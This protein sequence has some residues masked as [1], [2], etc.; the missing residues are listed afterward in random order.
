M[1][2]FYAD[3]TVGGDGSTTTDDT[4]ATTGLANGG[5]RTRLVPMFTQ[6]LNIAKWVRDTAA[7]TIGYK[8][9]ANNSAGL[10]NSRANAAYDAQL[11]A[12]R[13]LASA[14]AQVSLAAMQVDLAAE[15]K[16]LASDQVTLAAA[17]VVLA[18][19]WATKLVDPVT[20]GLYSARYYSQ[21]ALT[22]AQQAAAVTGIPIIDPVADRDKVMT[23]KA[24]GSGY[25]LR[26]ANAEQLAYIDLTV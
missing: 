23:A 22:Y 10:A 8:N 19:D 3:P 12:E 17:E 1:S 26:R 16:D 14:Q 5:F 9:E 7:L 13:A 18:S 2:S 6:V 20:G 15:Q 25:E 24:D 4:N 11:G 21:Q